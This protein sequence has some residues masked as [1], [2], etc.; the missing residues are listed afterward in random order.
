MTM[1]ELRSEST[2]REMEMTRVLQELKGTIHFVI[3]RLGKSQVPENTD[4][5]TCR[6]MLPT[7][8]VQEHGDKLQEVIVLRSTSSSIPC[9]VRLR[10]YNTP[11]TKAPAIKFGKG[12]RDFA[13]CNG[14]VV[15]DSLIFELRG[16]SQF[17]VYVF[18]GSGFP[19]EISSSQAPKDW[20]TESGISQKNG[21]CNS[22][23]AGCNKFQHLVGESSEGSEDI[24]LCE[25]VA[26]KRKARGED[27]ASASQCASQNPSFIKLRLSELENVQVSSMERHPGSQ[28][29]QQPPVVHQLF[30]MPISENRHD[31]Q[32]GPEPPVDHQRLRSMPSSTENNHIARNSDIKLEFHPPAKV[33][34]PSFIHKLVEYNVQDSAGNTSG[35]RFN[36]PLT[37][38]K[39]H[40]IRLQAHVKLQ[41]TREGSS[42]RIVTCS[43][44]IMQDGDRSSKVPLSLGWGDFVRDNALQAGHELVFTLASESFFVIREVSEIVVYT[45]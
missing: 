16:L 31:S 19:T 44:D 36:I 22:D 7:W 38:A 34:L 40:G 21:N 33:S 6:L 13:T 17:D 27:T 14:L 9:R 35:A 43:Y 11:A 30:G 24:D 39:R 10:I 4:S 3:D 15:G 45:K 32:N 8:F 37:F 29:S 1:A 25:V 23:G 2:A 28:K 41:G 42:H 12:W 26:R 5:E 18:R 20:S